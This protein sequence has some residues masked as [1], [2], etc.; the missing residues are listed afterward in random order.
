MPAKCP[1]ELLELSPTNEDAKDRKLRRARNQRAE[2]KWRKCM[3]IERMVRRRLEGKRAD[4]RDNRARMR[5][6]RK[7]GTHADDRK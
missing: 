6:R 5:K 7:H 4:G 1:R 2:D 3:E